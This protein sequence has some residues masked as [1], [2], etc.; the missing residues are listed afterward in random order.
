MRV[1]VSGQSLIW[2]SCPEC[3]DSLD[4]RRGKHGRFIGCSAYPQCDYAR[5]LNRAEENILDGNGYV[6]RTAEGRSRRR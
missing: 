2:G 1:E 3:G 6:D 5:S 4:L